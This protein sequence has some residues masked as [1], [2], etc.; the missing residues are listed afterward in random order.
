MKC[1]FYEKE[2]TPPLGSDMPG[3]YCH[4]YAQGV[5]DRLFVKA[6][7][8]CD[9]SGE[10]SA[11]TALVI[12]D[13]VEMHKHQIDAVIARASELTGIPVGAISVAAT[14]THYGIPC[15]DVISTEDTAYMEV[16][17][18]LAADCVAL[19]FQ[20][21]VSCKA[22]CAVGDARGLSFVRDYRMKDGNVVTNAGK[23]K[24]DIVCPNGEPDPDLPA[25]SF[26]AEDG[27]PIA[28]LFSFACHQDCAGGPSYTGDYSSEVS[29]RMKARY[30]QD[31]VSIYLA[32]AS[33]D[34]NHL[35]FIHGIRLNYLEMGEAFSKELIRMTDAPVF[36]SDTL[37]FSKE[38]LTVKRRVASEERKA[39]CR[40]IAESPKERRELYDM[41]GQNA[42][43]LLKYEEAF[44][45]T[46]L[47][48]E[49]PIHV[50]RVG[51]ARIFSLPG[52]LYSVFGN[53]LK[54]GCEGKKGLVCELSH[55]AAGYIPPKELFGTA[56]YPVQL[57][58]GS[59]LEEEAGEKLVK[60][61]LEISN[62]L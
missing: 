46:P 52:E 16:F 43:L 50:I 37:R 31:F 20:G 27:S 40:W 9:D 59:Y 48:V 45:G 30:G 1:G 61:T 10:A 15:G 3:G 6:A 36:M 62:T 35:D 54:D 11:C 51:E 39:K 29:R 33:G 22:S 32:G 57:C 49:L 53:A 5:K 2:I 17:C 25:I 47:E 41:T 12:V 21:L 18:R 4:R 42:S 8:F 44:E 19:A 55:M 24:E 23:Y 13:A 28:C 38:S 60:R 7:V 58:H 26:Y 56:A 14:H 34:I